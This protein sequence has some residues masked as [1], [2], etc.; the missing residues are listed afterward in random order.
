[1]G[2]GIEGRMGDLG[3]LVH[4]DTRSAN[5]FDV[6]KQRLYKCLREEILPS[7]G[8]ERRQQ[9]LAKGAGDENLT[10]TGN[11]RSIKYVA[12]RTLLH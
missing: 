10:S 7:T 6:P 5:I 1:M 11:K 2:V 9:I 8:K 3:C 12:S 4:Y